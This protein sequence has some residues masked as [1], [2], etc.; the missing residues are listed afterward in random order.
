MRLAS[1]CI[2]A[3]LL[4][5]LR[6]NTFVRVLVWSIFRIEDILVLA[7]GGLWMELALVQGLE[8]ADACQWMVLEPACN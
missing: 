1:I 6:L 2:E 7:D 4:A 3:H 8:Q 5:A